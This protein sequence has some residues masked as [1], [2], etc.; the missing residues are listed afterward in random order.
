M[1]N[2]AIITMFFAALLSVG[3]SI[4]TAGSASADDLFSKK[5]IFGDNDTLFDDPVPIKKT[6]GGEVTELKTQAAALKKIEQQHAVA[7]ARAE[8][9]GQLFSQMRAVASWVDNY[10]VW[11]HRFPELGDES[12][13]AFQQLNDLVPNNPY[14]SG[15][16]YVVPGVPS[17]NT[18]L[19]NEGEAIAP[20]MPG[21]K[22]DGDRIRF[23]RD[24][25]LTVLAV[26]EY[27]KD[28]PVDWG[29]APG[30]ITIITNDQYLFIVWGAGADGKP[31]RDYSTNRVRFAVGNYQHWDSPVM[32]MQID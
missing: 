14:R 13:A 25:G 26:D 6:E 29:A 19:K 27:S 28:P 7:N 24:Y 21:S 23:V 3:F 18:Y 10:V 30:T 20:P 11:N 5:S 4:A 2:C 9:D 1:T 31:L 17:D 15:A 16:S 32:D 22:V 8:N 12:T